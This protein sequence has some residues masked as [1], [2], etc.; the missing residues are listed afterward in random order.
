VKQYIPRRGDL[1]WLEFDPQSGREQAGHR[2]AIVLSPDFYNQ[3]SG[4]ALVCPITSQKKGYPFEIP[5]KQGKIEGVILTDQV[6]SLDW[7]RRKATF[8]AHASDTTIGAVIEN[9][10]ALLK[11]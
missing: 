7:K 8:A 3:A 6:K 4:L 9:I 5:I 1:I 2:P 11:E 10:T